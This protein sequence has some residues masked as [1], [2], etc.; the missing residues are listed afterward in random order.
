MY[1]SKPYIYTYTHTYDFE[2]VEDGVTLSEMNK[3]TSVAHLGDGE[4]LCRRAEFEILT[5]LICR[6][7]ALAVE[8][9]KKEGK[10]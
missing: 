6:Q 4:A 5:R 9:M 10:T 8:Y 3:T 1:I 7:W 2:E